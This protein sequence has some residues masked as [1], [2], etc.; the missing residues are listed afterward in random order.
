MAWNYQ[1]PSGTATLTWTGSD[2]TPAAYKALPTPKTFRGPTDP[3]T[4]TGVVLNTYD[5]WIVTTF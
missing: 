5:E 1:T 3:S 2:Y 4:V